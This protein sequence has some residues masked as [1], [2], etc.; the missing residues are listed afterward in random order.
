MNFYFYKIKCIFKFV[1]T[2]ARDSLFVKMIIISSLMDLRQRPWNNFNQLPLKAVD[3]TQKLSVQ[4][5]LHT[6]RQ[7]QQTTSF[8]LSF[9]Q[10]HSQGQKLLFI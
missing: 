6:S 3:G 1:Y 8:S 9:S 4:K 7:F 10:E 2:F 5:K